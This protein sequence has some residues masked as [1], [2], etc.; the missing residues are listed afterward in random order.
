MRKPLREWQHRALEA[1]TSNGRRGIVSAVT[2]GGKTVLALEAIRTFPGATSLVVVPTVA[3]LEQWWV[4]IADYF[5]LALDEVHLVKSRGRLHRGTVNLAVINTAATL[6]DGLS[7]CLLVVDECHKAASPVFRTVLE[8]KPSA[9]LGLSATPE[10]QYDDGLE[11]TLIPA[12]GPVLVRY[13]YREALADGVIVPFRLHNIVFDLEEETQFAYDKITRR[14]ARSIDSVGP[15][16]AE[17]ISLMLRRARVLNMSLARVKLALR[18]VARHRDRKVL[19]F[20]ENI[21][22]CE[23]INGVLQENGVRS[24]V[25]H[26]GQPVR[27]RADVLNSFRTSGVD[28]L[29]TCRALDEGFNV[30][31]TEVGIIAASTATRRQR[32]QRLGRVLRPAK[33]KESATVFTLVATKPEIDRLKYEEV[34]LEGVAETVW[35]SE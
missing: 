30:P 22:A 26:S 11:Q 7:G 14:L 31:E 18:L 32:I 35:S 10:R 24:G 15:D 3:L 20:H 2:G 6:R 23:L 19:V 1:W 16:A 33:N 29:V 9:T 21:G 25:Y 27:L 34:E 8:L 4:E 17:S 12:L 5:S 28:V 13:T